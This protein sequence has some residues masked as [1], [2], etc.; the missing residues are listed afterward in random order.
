MSSLRCVSGDLGYG[1]P[2]HAKLIGAGP[3][4][5]KVGAVRAAAWTRAN[6]V[7]DA[8]GRACVQGADPPGRQDLLDGDH[9]RAGSLK[10]LPTQL[11]QPPQRLL[12]SPVRSTPD[13][14]AP[15]SWRSS[16]RPPAS[17]LA[18][19][20]GVRRRAGVGGIQRR[21]PLASFI[22]TPALLR[23]GGLADIDLARSTDHPN[24]PGTATSTE[25]RRS[26]RSLHLDNRCGTQGARVRPK[27]YK[28]TRRSGCLP[29]VS[30]GVPWWH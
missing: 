21:A 23:F 18:R 22:P 14:A 2:A 27:E 1:P 20:V 5:G 13:I 17:L 12:G 10:E 8:V 28:Q 16:A 9:K 4:A 26:R 29:V 25:C 11:D 19:S 30:A 3:V 24:R 15:R 7:D 6:Q